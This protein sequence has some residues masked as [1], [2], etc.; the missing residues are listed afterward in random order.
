MNNESLSL[1]EALVRAKSFSKKGRIKEAIQLYQGILA[2]FPQHKKARKELKSLEKRN[3]GSHQARLHQDMSKLMRLY[4][5]GATE[6]A[7]SLATLLAMQHPDQ[8]LPLN[9]LGALKMEKEGPESAIELFRRAIQLEPAYPDAQSNLAYA[10]LKLERFELACEHYEIALSLSPRDADLHYQ[11][12]RAKRSLELREDALKQWQSALDIDSKHSKSMV[13]LGYLFISAGQ[14]EQAEEQFIK[15][16]EV[17]PDSVGA[18]RGL[19]FIRN[20]AGRHEEAI[21]YLERA[22]SLNSENSEAMEIKYMLS[23]LQGNSTGAAP[24]TYVANL[25]DGY[26]E[27]FEEHLVESLEYDTPRF[28]QATLSKVVP[29]LAHFSAALDLGCGTGLCGVAFRDSVGSIDGLDI[30]KKMVEKSREKEIYR[31]LWSGDV[32]DVLT[33]VEEKYQLVIAA[34]V[35]VYIGNLEPV[36]NQLVQRMTPDSYFTFSTEHTTESEFF[37]EKSLRY[38]H[39]RPY[40]E[41]I[42]S[43]AGFEFVH[44]ETLKL[45]KE[46]QQ[47]IAGAAYILHKP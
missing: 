31:N 4:T 34:D 43:S 11:L 40:I 38:T 22:L 24:G 21:G 6:E 2:S 8:P 7:F 20:K 37:L 29:H 13:A 42:A 12:G 44:F 5:E 17:D 45:R 18:L 14:L 1:D 36:F 46:N 32:L 10:M 16:M 28:L 19:G 39:S 23:A 9:I 26:A 27:N 35:F 30:S 41:K 15:A 25:F 47:W 33:S 3:P